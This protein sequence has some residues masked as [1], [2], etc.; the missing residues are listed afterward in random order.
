MENL[1]KLYF[2]LKLNK[3]LDIQQYIFLKNQQTIFLTIIYLSNKRASPLLDSDGFSLASHSTTHVPHCVCSAPKRLASTDA[4]AT[5]A[6]R[7]A[8]N[9][10]QQNPQSPADGRRSPGS[11]T[12]VTVAK[13]NSQ[14]AQ[15][16]SLRS[17]SRAS[18][19]FSGSR[20]RAPFLSQ[21]SL[22]ASP[23]A[24]AAP[25]AH[26]GR[27]RQVRRRGNERPPDF[28]PVVR[29][30]DPPPPRYCRRRLSRIWSPRFSQVL[31]AFGVDQTKGLSDSQVPN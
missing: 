29:S 4:T 12:G 26:G 31:E 24:A 14:T 20:S 3:T 7:A 11:C 15:T 5:H 9:P 27:L 22:P 17:S 8:P 16:R 2:F 21:P 6:T 28:N 25:A 19:P 23:E 10:D 13:H 1:K 30:F 18:S